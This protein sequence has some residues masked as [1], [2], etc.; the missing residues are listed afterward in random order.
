[1]T[2]KVLPG[3]TNWFAYA[4][5]LTRAHAQTLLSDAEVERRYLKGCLD[6]SEKR[7]DRL[8]KTVEIYSQ[9]AEDERE[10]AR[11]ITAQ[12]KGLR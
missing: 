10:H 3:P 1:M 4:A 6:A 12:I 2:A 8:T 5:E 9:M 11:L 7:L